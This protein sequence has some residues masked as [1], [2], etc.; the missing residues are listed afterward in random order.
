MPVDS[1]RQARGRRSKSRGKEDERELARL[2][3][4]VRFKAD[5]GGSLDCDHP[6]LALQVKGGEKACQPSALA[7]GLAQARAGA[8]ETGKLPAL[9]IVVHAGRGRRK[10]HYL[11]FEAAEFAAWHGLGPTSGPLEGVE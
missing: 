9:G 1:V 8:C 6:V 2:L 3:G 10:A 5:T 4:A 7:L 11:V